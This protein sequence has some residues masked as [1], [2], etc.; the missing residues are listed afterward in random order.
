MK[1]KN[2]YELNPLSKVPGGYHL[3]IK[4]SNGALQNAHNIK[5]PFHYVKTVISRVAKE[6][7]SVSR[8]TTAGDE[9]V[10][11]NGEFTPDFVNTKVKDSL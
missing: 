7:L 1:T 2:L 6:G 10:F 11:T 4:L 3:F 8:V 9:V 5:S